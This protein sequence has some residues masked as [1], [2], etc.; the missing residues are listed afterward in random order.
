MEKKGDLADLE[1]AR[2]EPR[3]VAGERRGSAAWETKV[4]AENYPNLSCSIQSAN[5]IS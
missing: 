3:D 4:V 5:I 1:P 2:S